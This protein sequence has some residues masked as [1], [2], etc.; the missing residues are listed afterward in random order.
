MV[1]SATLSSGCPSGDFPDRYGDVKAEMF[2]RRLENSPDPGDIFFAFA[3]PEG[4]RASAEG[5][6]LGM[7]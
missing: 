6:G 5:D 3:N 4:T 2:E 1:I 7:S